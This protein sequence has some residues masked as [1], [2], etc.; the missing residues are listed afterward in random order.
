MSPDFAEHAHNYFP[1][2]HSTPENALRADQKSFFSGPVDNAVDSTGYPNAFTECRETLTLPTYSI[3][4][5]PQALTAPPSFPLWDQGAPSIP[6]E[7]IPK[8][9]SMNSSTAPSRRICGWKDDDKLNRCKTMVTPDN[10]QEHLATSHGIRN[11][12]G[13]HPLRCRTC[14]QPRRMK[15][16]SL[17]RHYR[18]V[19]FGQKRKIPMKSKSI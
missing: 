17:L 5:L 4:Y 10:I 11:L 16:E 8:A 15:R 12:A 19:H 14:N 7:N 6:A 2:N 13:D 18:E 9:V 1:P 3:T